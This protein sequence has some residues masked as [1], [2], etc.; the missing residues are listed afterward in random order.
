MRDANNLKALNTLGVDWVGFIFYPK[1]KRF[2][3]EAIETSLKSGQKWVGV[4]VDETLQGVRDHVFRFNLDMVQLHGDESPEYCRQLKIPGLQVI[5]AFSV[6]RNFDFSSCNDY[7]GTVD[8]FLFDTKGTLPGGNGIPYDWGLLENYL[9]DVPFMLSGGIGPEFVEQIKAFDHPCWMGID[10][11]SRFE[12]LPAVKDI[13][14]LTKF[15]YELF[16]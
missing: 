6:D 14:L 12:I 16:S 2:V 13:D 7:T 1:S 15:K 9:G 3:Q 4:F 10:L 5:K 8:Y 11:N